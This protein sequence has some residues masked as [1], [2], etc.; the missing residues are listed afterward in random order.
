MENKK[1]KFLITSVIVSLILTLIALPMLVY[2]LIQNISISY[3][4]PWNLII[5]GVGFFSALLAWLVSSLYAYFK[6][7][8]KMVLTAAIANGIALIFML[9]PLLPSIFFV[10]SGSDEHGYG[11]MF[12]WI[13]LPMALATIYSLVLNIKGYRKLKSQ[14]K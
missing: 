6:G 13:F 1:N 7:N 14:N 4:T 12:I 9:F 11:I 5:L 8:L 3:S 2:P 10:L